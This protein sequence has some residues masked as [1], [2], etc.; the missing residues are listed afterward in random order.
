MDG[1]CRFFCCIAGTN[2]TVSEFN[3]TAFTDESTIKIRV[4]IQDVAGNMDYAERSL[5]INQDGDRP[6]VR[7]TNVRPTVQQ[8]C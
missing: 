1:R 3:T 8:P 6:V 4:G 7:L 2:W 5:S